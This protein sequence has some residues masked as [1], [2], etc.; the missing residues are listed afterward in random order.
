MMMMMMMIMMIIA[1]S[2]S[3]RFTGRGVLVRSRD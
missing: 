1:I 2:N 3:K